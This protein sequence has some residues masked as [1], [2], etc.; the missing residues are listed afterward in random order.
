MLNSPP[1]IT[2]VR[3]R[4]GISAQERLMLACEIFYR[5]DTFSEANEQAIVPDGQSED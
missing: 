3:V 2:L 4:R 1:A 5:G